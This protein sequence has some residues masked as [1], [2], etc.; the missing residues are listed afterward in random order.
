MSCG[1]GIIAFILISIPTLAVAYVIESNLGNPNDL[2]SAVLSDTL[3]DLISIPS[4]Y[5]AV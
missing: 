1:F 4:M 3:V 5:I 2:I